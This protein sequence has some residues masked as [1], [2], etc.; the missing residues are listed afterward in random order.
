MDRKKFIRG[1]AGTLSG[2]FFLRQLAIANNSMGTHAGQAG[3]GASGFSV[4][5]TAKPALVHQEPPPYNIDLVKEF[6]IAGHGNFDKAQSMVKDHPN[7][8]F[9]KFDWGNG[10]FEAAIEGAGHVGNREIAE[11]L[12]DAG[13]RVT[14]F[15]L[16]MLGRTELVKPVL[17]A[18]PKLIFAYGP[19]GFTLLHHAKVGRKA[20]EELYAYLQEKGLKEDWIKIR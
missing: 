11:F 18:Y 19:H 10:D 3:P 14:L 7:L 17:E 9:S 12:I 13:S 15:V 8:I 4:A 1:T 2:L 20:G 5:D 16:T 6:V